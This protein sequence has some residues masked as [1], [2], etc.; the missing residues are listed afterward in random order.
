[1]KKID[2]IVELHEKLSGLPEE[3][4]RERIEFYIEMIEDRIEEGELEE[5]AVQAVGTI[6][7]IA[8]AILSEIPFTR[9]VKEK[10]KPKRSLG[11]WTIVLLVL[12]SPI[13]ISLLVCVFAIIIAIYTALWSVVISLWATLTALWG[14]A[15]GAIMSG[16]VFMIG[17]HASVGIAMIA[18]C[19][20]LAG[21]SIFWFYG[22]K[23]A[24]KGTI[25]LAKKIMLVIK[26]CFRKREV[27]K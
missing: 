22:C 24:T 11:A 26:K 2:F 7:E 10:I 5:D 12:G 15:L 17:G 14:G 6:E 8:D 9:L 18:A 25:I 4:V 3:E 16:I 19:L 1:M 21:L 13:W 27:T 20:V 23:L